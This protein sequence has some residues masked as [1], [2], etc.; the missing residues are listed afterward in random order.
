M[1]Q[2]VFTINRV[3]KIVPPK[4]QIL[5]GLNDA[6]SHHMKTSVGVPSLDVDA[7]K[8]MMAGFLK[9]SSVLRIESSGRCCSIFMS[10][11]VSR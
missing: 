4:R 6:D 1:A 2:Y 9:R 3:S 10:R 11:T 8:S 5:K 7:A